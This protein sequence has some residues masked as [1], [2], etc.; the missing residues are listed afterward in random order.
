MQAGESSWP[1]ASLPAGVKGSMAEMGTTTAAAAAAA[2]MEAVGRVGGGPAPAG[3]LSIGMEGGTDYS[4]LTRG[5]R[6]QQHWR[7]QHQ[8][9]QLGLHVVRAQRWGGAIRWVGGP[10]S[11]KMHQLVHRCISWCME[12]SMGAA[13][14]PEQVLSHSWFIS[15]SS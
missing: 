15:S 9:R 5:Q 2:S 7:R 11:E 12:P 10:F 14:N 8:L 1:A 3:D 13:W 4:K 6:H